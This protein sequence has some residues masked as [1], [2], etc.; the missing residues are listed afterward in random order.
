MEPIATAR[1]RDGATVTVEGTVIASRSL[2]DASGRR[3]VLED[4]SAAI[5]LYLAA[6]DAAV[7]PGVRL[8]VTGVI[9]RAWGAP[10]LRASSVTVLGTA[11]PR[12]IDLRVA[13]GP[14]TEWH[15]A[16]LSGT[17]S[18][19]HRTG[20]R[21]VAELDTGFATVPLIGLD[22]AGIPATGLDVGRRATVTGI[23]RRPYPTAADRRYQL[24]PR[25]PADLELG[26]A[27]TATGSSG[28]GSGAGAPGATG[29]PSHPGA[30]N[31]AAATPADLRDLPSL[32]GQR[33]HVGGLVGTLEA[34]G[35]QLDDGT[36]SA[37]VVLTGDAADL[38]AVVGPGDALNADGTVELRDEVVLVVSDPAALVLVGALGGV[39]ATSSVAPAVAA[40]LVVL[41]SAAPGL[42]IGGEPPTDPTGAVA[43]SIIV[44]G[45]AV[46]VGIAAYAA[47]RRRDRRRLRARILERVRTVAGPS[48]PTTTADA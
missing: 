42:R 22:G 25:Q 46:G 3:T 14:A 1:V 21:W 36:A 31:S 48:A 33:V 8:R 23:V 39:D 10:R 16:R 38:I 18:S 12:V 32:V 6:P 29:D 17:I 20:S 35:F 5:E 40:G 2:L 45:T 43:L 13:P 7:R 28:P 15:L 30:S 34:D 24:V 4:A 47:R 26:A 27:P 41:D 9:G 44:A 11:T 37:R 19:I